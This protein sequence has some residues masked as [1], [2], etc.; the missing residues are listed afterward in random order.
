MSTIVVGYDGSAAAEAALARGIER[1]GASGRLCVVHA[2][3]PPRILRGSTAYGVYSAWSYER[4]ELELEGLA[5]QHPELA[6]VDWQARVIAGSPANVL[7]EVATE[8]GAD[9]IIVG[10]HGA[11]RARALLGS[12]AH[13]VIHEA[14]C[15]V[16]VIPDRALRRAAADPAPTTAR[17]AS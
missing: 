8:I 9:E 7:A 12:V 3:I 1:T 11:G 15:P 10:S 5:E 13:G 16:T 4:A 14:A 2:W 6:S 17:S